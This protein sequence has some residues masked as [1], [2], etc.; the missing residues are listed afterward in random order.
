MEA[1]ICGMGEGRIGLE[2][3]DKPDLEKEAKK[4]NVWY[5]TSMK[6]R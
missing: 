5:R 6:Y 4:R 1:D 2:S 3:I